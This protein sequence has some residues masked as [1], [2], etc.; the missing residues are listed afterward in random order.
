MEMTSWTTMEQMLRQTILPQIT[1][2][3]NNSLEAEILEVRRLVV[4]I[5]GDDQ[6]LDR[7]DPRDREDLMLMVEVDPKMDME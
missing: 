4:S 3:H 7:L 6:H 5:E 2:H 1:H